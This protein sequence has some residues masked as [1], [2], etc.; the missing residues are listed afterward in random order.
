MQLTTV[1]LPV[2]HSAGASVGGHAAV[3]VLQYTG[4]WDRGAAGALRLHVGRLDLFLVTGV[5]A[6]ARARVHMLLKHVRLHAGRQP[7]LLRSSWCT[8][9]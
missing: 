2:H 4:R 7:G 6:C 9:P 1:A 8:V 5:G 3:V